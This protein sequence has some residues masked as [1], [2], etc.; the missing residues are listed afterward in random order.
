MP[1]E[2]SY[3]LFFVMGLKRNKFLPQSNFI[4][5]LYKYVRIFIK[6]HMYSTIHIFRIFYT[7][8]LDVLTIKIFQGQ[9]FVRDHS[10][11]PFTPASPS[12]LCNQWCF[13]GSVFEVCSEETHFIISL[14]PSEHSSLHC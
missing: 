1:T 13:E 11:F 3:R 6:C 14:T 10:I 5:S 4:F 9:C 2:G 12:T 7:K 8:T